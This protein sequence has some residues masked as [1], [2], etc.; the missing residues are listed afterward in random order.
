MP[1]ISTASRD[2]S[3]SSPPSARSARATQSTAF[4]DAG[5]PGPTVKNRFSAATGAVRGENGSTDSQTATT[6]IRRATQRERRIAGVRR[7]QRGR[8]FVQTPERKF[9]KRAAL[10]INLQVEDT[11]CVAGPYNSL[12][13]DRLICTRDFGAYLD[14]GPATAYAPLA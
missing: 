1:L 12:A 10:L 9:Y 13:P 7:R 4:D 11:E 6:P 8:G 2:R 5:A 14:I 3:F